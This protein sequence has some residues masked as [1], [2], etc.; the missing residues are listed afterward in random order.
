MEWFS[1]GLYVGMWAKGLMEGNGK[2]TS[3]D[4]KVYEVRVASSP[5]SFR[6]AQPLR[7]RFLH[8]KPEPCM[9]GPRC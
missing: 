8:G 4:G 3:I 9:F 6:A 5:V 7:Q 2:F 1:G